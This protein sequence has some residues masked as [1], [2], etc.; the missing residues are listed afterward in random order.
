MQLY[1]RL[2]TEVKER[3][4]EDSSFECF[5]ARLWENNHKNKLDLKSMAYGMSPLVISH[6]LL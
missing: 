5:A 1:I 3:M 6:W 2:L 4:K